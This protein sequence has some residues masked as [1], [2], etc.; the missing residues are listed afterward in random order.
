MKTKQPDPNYDGPLWNVIVRGTK[1]WDDQEDERKSQGCWLM[2]YGSVVTAQ[3]S[4]S[5]YS[6]HRQV[7]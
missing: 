3:R 1:E 5:R 7:F 4:N 2:S 6:M